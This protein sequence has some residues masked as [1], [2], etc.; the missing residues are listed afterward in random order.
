[1]AYGKV[2][3]VF[4]QLQISGTNL[5]VNIY[6]R[7]MYTAFARVLQQTGKKFFLGPR[8]LSQESVNCFVLLDLRPAPFHYP[9]TFYSFA[10][11]DN[12]VDEFLIK[13]KGRFSCAGY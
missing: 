4:N 12:P 3:T 5:I 6:E 13:L 8:K 7:I 10:D 2:P 1:M 11:P 9:L